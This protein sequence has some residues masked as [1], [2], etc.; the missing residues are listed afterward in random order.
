MTHDSDASPHLPF[1]LPLAQLT[2]RFAAL[3]PPATDGGTLVS[4][5]CRHPSGDRGFPETATL[6]T[7]AGLAG[8]RWAPGKWGTGNQIT[9]MRAD[10]GALVGN[11]QSLGTFGDNLLVDL[12]LSRDNLPT[13]TQLKVGAVVLEVTEVPHDG[14][15]KYRARFGHDALR[16]TAAAEN[17]PLR[18]RGIHARVLRSGVVTVGDTITVQDRGG[19]PEG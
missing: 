8:D 14:C 10:V 5:V 11:G 9:L 4:V 12:D 16:F 2:E 6:T 17:R 1:H 19:Q 3:P 13:G 7:E 18:L 15:R